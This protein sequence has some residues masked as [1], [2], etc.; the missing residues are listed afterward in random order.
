MQHLL[1]TE[2]ELSEQ[3][4]VSHVTVRKAFAALDSQGYLEKKSGKGTFIAE[5]KM[6]RSLY[7]RLRKEWTILPQAIP[8]YFPKL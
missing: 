4:H 2:N 1:P 7:V 8:D 5:K 3:Y 6:Q